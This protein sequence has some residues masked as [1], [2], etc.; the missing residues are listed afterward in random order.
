MK[1]QVLDIIPHLKNP[2]T[3]EIVSTADRLNQVVETARRAE[4]LG[5]DSFSVGERHAG[6]F[7]SSSPTTVL[8]AIASVTSRIRLQTGVTVLSVLDPV[9]VAEDYATIDQ[10]SRGRLEL[11]IGKGNEVLQYPLFGLSLDDQWDLL[12]EKYALLRTLW[13]KESVTWSGR[14]RPALT[15]PTTT[16]PRPFAGSPRIWHGSATTLTSAA[17][18][19]KWGDPLFTA[20]AIQPRENYKVLIDHYR[21]EYERHGH[22]PRHQYLGS[23]SGAGGVFI[24]DTTQE[25]IRQYGP[26]YEGLTANR[27]V[28]GNN[29]PFRDIQHAVAEGPALV[30]SPEQVI[31]KI[32]SYHSLYNHDL[33]SISL[34]TTLPFEQQL[35]ILE[36]FAL[37][38]I[39]AVRASAPTTLWESS[40]PFGGRPEFAGATEPDAAATVAADHAFNRTDNALVYAH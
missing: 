4:E 24:A 36:R 3:G 8:A 21:E 12:A 9:R 26:V 25:A 7:V 31:H 32:L 6:E 20:N 17:L 27:N 38:V 22:D 14:F 34:P 37:E 10:L 19:A 15:E 13:R 18:A 16:T 5:F 11:V 30:G 29:S 23:G 28:P 35:E 2:V 33:Q 1:F 40:D 39:P